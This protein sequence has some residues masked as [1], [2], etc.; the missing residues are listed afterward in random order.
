MLEPLLTSDN[1]ASTPCLSD[2]PDLVQN[3]LPTFDYPPSIR[4]K[5]FAWCL[6]SILIFVLLISSVAWMLLHSLLVL[7]LPFQVIW[8]SG[9]LRLKVA[10]SPR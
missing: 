8:A 2:L 6:I 4:M 7:P 9:I 5:Q 3:D 10:C 1:P